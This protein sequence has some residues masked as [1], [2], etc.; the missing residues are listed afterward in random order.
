M[1]LAINL[2]IIYHGGIEGKHI[3]RIYIIDY[4]F[5]KY[6]GSLI[7]PTYIRIQYEL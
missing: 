3:C 2:Y 4:I 1:N 7:K 6:I 5:D